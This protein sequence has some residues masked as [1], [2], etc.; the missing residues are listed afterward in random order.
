[1]FRAL[2][3]TQTT[4]ETTPIR[5]FIKGRMLRVTVLIAFATAVSAF[6]AGV[7]LKASSPSTGR[8]VIMSAEPSVAALKAALAKAQ[9]DVAN[10]KTPIAIVNAQQVSAR[11]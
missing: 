11:A 10:A 1:M 5:L 9:A 2:S 8:S 3:S 4:S 7:A 6:N